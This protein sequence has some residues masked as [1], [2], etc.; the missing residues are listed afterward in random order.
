MQGECDQWDVPLEVH[1]VVARWVRRILAGH[2][3]DVV[4][5]AEQRLSRTTET[6]V[7]MVVPAGARA[8]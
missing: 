7:S 8:R 2:E 4:A 6:T 1:H 3:N 5:D